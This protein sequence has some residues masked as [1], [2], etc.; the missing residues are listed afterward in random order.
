MARII[1]FALLLMLPLSL[2]TPLLA[3][4]D[5][6]KWVRVNIP[7]QGKAGN[8]VLASGSN[9]QHLTAAVDGTLYAYSEGLDH[10]LYKS[11]DGGYSWSHTGRVEDEIV[12]IATAPDDAE[13][14]YYA[15]ISRIFKSTDGGQRF[16]ELAENPG[17][18]DGDNIT[19]TDIDVA[20]LN[21]E[22]VIAVATGDSDKSEFGGVYILDESNPFSSWID[23]G[24]GSH[25][26]YAIAFSPDFATDK[27][28][29]AVLTDET[30]TFVSSKIGN[31]AW[32]QTVGNARL[33]SS[34]TSVT[35][36]TSAVIVF[37]SDYDLTS[38]CVHFT[39]KFLK[40]F[41]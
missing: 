20:S 13:N 18:A 39:D 41:T 5:D 3:S 36:D 28:L 24:A 12:A 40:V 6:V 14:I 21:G 4:S 38:N 7:T 22:S 33:L 31:A 37:P 32:G 25:D 35:V 1:S 9:I 17:V 19:I 15:T 27:Q 26:V 34:E 11:T 23:T 29:V 16:A 10:T 30:D 2:I 8:W